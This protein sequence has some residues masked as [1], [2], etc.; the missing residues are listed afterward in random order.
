MVLDKMCQ[1]CCPLDVKRVHLG[2][3]IF[4]P[5]T[6]CG[7]SLLYT[8]SFLRYVVHFNVL[9]LNRLQLRSLLTCWHDM[10]C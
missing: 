4:V 6:R 1:A 7:R 10:T 8:I 9:T 2:T 3:N 5:L